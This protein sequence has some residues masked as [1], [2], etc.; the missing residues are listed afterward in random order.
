MAHEVL[1]WGIV[2]DLGY[3]VRVFRDGKVP[4]IIS[5]NFLI[6]AVTYLGKLNEGKK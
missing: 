3:K 5:S 6:T 2:I 1:D 4:E